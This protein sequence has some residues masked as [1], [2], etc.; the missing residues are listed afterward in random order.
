MR[1]AS[2]V[3]LLIFMQSAFAADVK[4]SGVIYS[5]PDGFS[6]SRQLN[7]Q[8]DQFRNING[9]S[10]VITVV[11]FSSNL[12]SDQ[13]ETIGSIEK[14]EQELKKTVDILKKANV[15]HHFEKKSL[16]D[17]A[18]LILLGSQML[19][20]GNGLPPKG[21]IYSEIDFYIFWSNSS[22]QLHG[23]IEWPGELKPNLESCIN[24]IVTIRREN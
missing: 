9:E 11:K 10:W 6:L 8:T 5:V 3:I 12:P 1:I 17:G 16:N 21:K 24:R 19:K 20:T 15:V 23:R 7:I 2:F 14:R 18:T 4:T 22:T 13:S